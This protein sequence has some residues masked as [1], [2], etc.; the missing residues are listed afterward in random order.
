MKRALIGCLLLMGCGD[1][2]T[3]GPGGFGGA[4]GGG[5]GGGGAGPTLLIDARDVNNRTELVAGVDC[6]A[7]DATGR[8]V[9]HVV[10]ADTPV[11]IAAPPGGTISIVHQKPDV[12]TIAS[13]RVTDGLTAIHGIVGP[14]VPPPAN[15]PM[16][17]VH[18]EVTAP[19]EILEVVVLLSCGTEVTPIYLPDSATIT[20]F[21]GC[22]GKD[23]F[24]AIGLG[25][26]VDSKVVAYDYVSDLPFVAG[27]EATVQFDMNH[28]LFGDFAYDLTNIPA[29]GVVGGAFV[30]LLASEQLAGYSDD[31]ITFGGL[32]GSS[33][34]GVFRVPTELPGRVTASINVSEPADAAGRCRIS[35][36]QRYDLDV[37]DT[38]S[39]D[40]TGDL[41]AVS[42]TGGDD[43]P[44]WSVEGTP[45]TRILLSITATAANWS[46]NF[47]MYDDPTLGTR[48]WVLPELPEELADFNPPSGA[49]FVA[50]VAHQDIAGRS[51]VEETEMGVTS[52]YSDYTESL[53]KS[54]TPD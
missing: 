13:Y 27:G 2:D 7:N 44:T 46:G 48:T 41:G 14:Y 8:L 5:D 28:T 42:L 1:S 33:Y 34:S 12:R 6:I 25:F 23:T 45:R 50:R 54:C 36:I 31:F 4:G 47:T 53:V 15:D 18:A 26:N 37:A 19:P 11:A 39:W 51:Y 49:T 17:A 30:N 35:T 9:D 40:V 22:P 43:A 38:L 16:S 29:S 32:V 10:T 3:T 21:V 52:T 24:S 20:D